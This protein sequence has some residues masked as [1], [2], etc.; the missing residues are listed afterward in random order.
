[1]REMLKESHFDCL[2]LFRRQVGYYISYPR[3]FITLLSGIR[4]ALDGGC[5]GC[6]V[7]FVL[8][9]TRHYSQA[10][11]A[12]AQSIDHSA[13]RQQHSPAKDAALFRIVGPGARPYL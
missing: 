4:S 11:A 7:F 9:R 13:S 6:T 12:G 2:A 10:P 3:C 5:I 8:S 1:M